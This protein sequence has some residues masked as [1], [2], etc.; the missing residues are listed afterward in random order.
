M[1]SSGISG[2]GSGIGKPAMLLAGG[3]SDDPQQMVRLLS[4][5]L[6]SQPNPVIA[7]IGTANGDSPI[8]FERMA[9]SLYQAGAKEVLLVSLATDTPALDKAREILSAADTIFLAGGEVE[10]GI[11]WLKRHGID[12]LLHKLY[13][14]GKLFVGVSAGPIMMGSHWVH[15]DVP[16]KYET[17]SLFDCLG[18]IPALFDV[19]GEEEDWHELKTALRLLG[20]GAQGYALPRE[21]MISADNQ[22]RMVNLAKEPL[23]FVNESGQIRQK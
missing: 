12:K 20:D 2:N 3:R 21:S 10:D 4:Q 15:W 14:E 13:K 17:A 19:H 5:A 22:G 11:Y 16:E 9:S 1:S 6:S 7:Y 18:I 23:V 8:Y